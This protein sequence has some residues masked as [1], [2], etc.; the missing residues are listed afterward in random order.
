MKTMI[1][2]ESNKSTLLLGHY[3]PPPPDRN[4][5]HELMVLLEAGKSLSLWEAF[6]PP[7]GELLSYKSAAALCSLQPWPDGKALHVSVCG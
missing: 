3:T 7:S 2:L 4:R 1:T 6:H 5:R